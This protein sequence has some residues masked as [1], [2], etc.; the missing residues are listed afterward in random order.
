MKQRNPR[1]YLIKPTRRELLTNHGNQQREASKRCYQT[2]NLHTGFLKYWVNAM[3]YLVDEAI[4]TKEGEP[5]AAMA[6][7]EYQNVR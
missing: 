3:S 4:I 6:G 2:V 5:A 1:C 7:G